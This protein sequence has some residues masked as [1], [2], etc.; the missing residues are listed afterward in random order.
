M[1]LWVEVAEGM[2]FPSAPLMS[3]H[4]P[5][6]EKQLSALLLKCFEAGQ[7]RPEERVAHGRVA[8]A[9]I[10]DTVTPLTRATQKPRF[11][12]V[13]SLPGSCGG[14]AGKLLWLKEIEK[15]KKNGTA[16]ADEKRSKLSCYCWERSSTAILCLWA[17]TALANEP[18]G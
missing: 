16:F 14:A 18:L 5:V 4:S 12:P 13:R 9:K 1:Q 10:H 2:G 6:T 8:L 3:P 15:E 17:L 11:P 7:H